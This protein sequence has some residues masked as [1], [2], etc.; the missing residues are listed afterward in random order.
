[1][2]KDMPDETRRGME[3]LSKKMRERTKRDVARG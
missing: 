1:M 3:E 2:G